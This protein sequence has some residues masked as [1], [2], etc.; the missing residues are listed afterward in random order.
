[1]LLYNSVQKSRFLIF[2]IRAATITWL[3]DGQLRK[4]KYFLQNF[5]E[6]HSV[7]FEIFQSGRGKWENSLFLVHLGEIIL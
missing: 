5:I 3:V 2:L 4:C 1:M 7:V 6:I